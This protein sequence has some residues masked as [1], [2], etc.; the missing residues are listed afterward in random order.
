M[1]QTV[2]A[3]YLA[4]YGLVDLFSGDEAQSFMNTIITNGGY[5]V[6]GSTQTTVYFSQIP[7]SEYT[8][9]SRNR[10][11]RD[12]RDHRDHRDRD[13]KD[14]RDREVKKDWICKSCGEMNFARRAACYGCKQPKTADA[15]HIERDAN[16]LVVPPNS[17]SAMAN[18]YVFD[19]NT[20]YWYNAE[21]RLYYDP[22]TTKYL[23]HDPAGNRFLVYDEA[24]A[25][26]LPYEAPAA[27]TQQVA[28]PVPEPE[29]TEDEIIA[30]ARAVATQQAEDLREGPEP[31]TNEEI[32]ARAQQKAIARTEELR[33]KLQSLKTKS[34]AERTKAMAA[35]KQ[36]L[37]SVAS[38][39]ASTPTQLTFTFTTESTSAPANPSATTEVTDSAAP[40]PG[41]DGEAV[42]IVGTKDAP[43]NANKKKP[44]IKMKP[45]GQGLLA[46]TRLIAQKKQLAVED[47]D[48]EDDE[49]AQKKAKLAEMTAQG[50]LRDVE[51]QR[52]WEQEFQAAEEREKRRKVRDQD[53]RERVTRRV[54]EHRDDYRDRDYDRD[55]DRDSDRDRDRESRARDRD[56]HS[57]DRDRDRDRNRDFDRDRDRDYR[58]RD[59][60]ESDHRGD[61]DRRGEQFDDRRS[62]GSSGDNNSSNNADFPPRKQS[63]AALDSAPRRPPPPS[64]KRPSP[65]TSASQPPRSASPPS[66]LTLGP[67]PP[68]DPSGL[69][70]LLCRRKFDAPEKYQVHKV[71]SKLH[72]DNLKQWRVTNGFTNEEQGEAQQYVDRA[73]ERRRRDG[74]SESQVHAIQREAIL[75]QDL[76]RR[77]YLAAQ[78]SSHASV[79]EAVMRNPIPASV[80]VDV[81]RI[82]PASSTSPPAEV[83]DPLGETN[84]G[85]K[86]LKSMQWSEGEGLGKHGKGRT[87]AI[88][89][90]QRQERQ[91]L[92]MRQNVPGVGFSNPANRVNP[93]D[94]YAD[95]TRKKLRARF[96]ERLLNE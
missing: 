83:A 95:A 51:R 82:A 6:V 9:S 71:A 68:E 20:N 38:T 77:P 60:R 81:Q 4:L 94:S 64:H 78:S 26:Y 76:I 42:T 88:E 32:H 61:R 27:T 17:G 50:K 45:I 54:E 7:A 62:A 63:S 65:H 96:E 39:I 47:E 57:D 92:G 35:I 25:S 85:Y 33:A 28:E 18:G 11:Y 86:M 31:L 74:V 67:M 24:T 55:R 58:S 29:I 84:V 5:F 12:H 22:A 40:K 34:P 69:V 3:E 75:K 70:C 10:R 46:S 36:L 37:D 14:W 56:Y 2:Q 87:E 89:V 53:V 59:Y 48:D 15:V 73:A 43:A 80:A 79:A 72:L 16:G 8:R 41:G 91:G 44:V 30:Y 93:G 66:Q 13:D 19:P 23:C 49:P 90:E 1:A 21:T 52:A